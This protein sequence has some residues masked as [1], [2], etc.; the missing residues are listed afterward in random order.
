MDD[1]K[2]KAVLNWSV[3]QS[4]RAF[5]GLVG[6]YHR[7]IHAYGTI[8]APLSKLLHKE[9]FKWCAEAEAAFHA[10]KNALTMALVLQ[11]LDFERDFIV[12]CDASGTG[13]RAVLH[14]G[15]R[16]VAFFS[17]QIV[18]RHATPS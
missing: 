13:F 14:Q 15:D 5:L 4:V 8:G 10:L 6:Y 9:G 17:K 7:F 16:S 18:R 2:I 11:P 1:Q 3:P 12:E